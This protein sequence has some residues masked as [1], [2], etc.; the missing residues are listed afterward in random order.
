[1]YFSENYQRNLTTGETLMLAQLSVKAGTVTDKHQCENEE[2]IYLVRG[3]L[4]IYLSASEV[5][6][7]P[8]QTFVVPK[9]TFYTA[10]ATA[11][12]DAVIFSKKNEEWMNNDDFWSQSTS[13]QF[14]WAV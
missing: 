9:N 4:K 14:L 2:I 12:S 8:G 5:L 10:E 11:D 13:E 7:R 6:L 1:M 3:E